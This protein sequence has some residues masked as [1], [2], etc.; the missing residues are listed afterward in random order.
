MN[1]LA[2]DLGA[3]NGRAILGSLS[4]GRLDIKEIRR[5]PND[6][7]RTPAHLHW[8]LPR[9]LYEIQQ[10]LVDC[11]NDAGFLPD[12]IGVNTWGVDFG[13]IDKDGDLVFL[14]IHYRDESRDNI[15]DE[16]K[17][18]ITPEQ[19]FYRSGYNMISSV[20]SLFYLFKKKPHITKAAKTILF[21]PDLLGFFLCGN[22]YAERSICSTS[23]LLDNETGEWSLDTLSE[24]GIDLSYLPEVVE[25]GTQA[26]NVLPVILDTLGLNGNVKVVAVAGHDTAS[27]AAAVPAR[28]DD[29][30]YISCG[31]WSVVGAPAQRTICTKD[32]FDSKGSFDCSVNGGIDMRINICG[33]WIQQ[34]IRRCF[35]LKGKDYSFPELTQLAAAAE[36]F[37]AIIDPDAELFFHPGNMDEK[38]RRFCKESGQRIPDSTGELSRVVLESLALK[39]RY[40]IDRMEKM[41]SKK[42]PVIYMIG[43][44][45]QNELLCQFTASAC[46]RPVTAGPVEATV[47]GNLLMQAK[48]MGQIN[49]MDEG[50]E[51]VLASCEIKNYKPD[52]SG[53]WDRQ[54]DL[55][56]CIFSK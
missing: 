1:F 5:F 32:I 42:L 15:T 50:R 27:A 46:Q 37:T 45:V 56:K 7:V 12:S 21:T 35:A 38:V 44:G 29:F 19:L 8:D 16:L 17:R 2:Y 14:P 13:L 34:E 30:A 26:G 31:T 9:L 4:N 3:S 10:S 47:F 6:P 25:P 28:E 20:E 23:K 54:F 24:L 33:L 11:N 51:L 53:K 49:N 36:P 40:T 41:L 55:A 52:D 39:Y 43:G 48:A 18:C 22:R